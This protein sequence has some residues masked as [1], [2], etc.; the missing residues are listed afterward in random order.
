MPTFGY[1][2]RP[3]TMFTRLEAGTDPREETLPGNQRITEVRTPWVLRSKLLLS[4]TYPRSSAFPPR[5]ASLP[6]IDSIL[7]SEQPLNANLSQEEEALN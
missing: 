2:V 6:A 3:H 4:P 5:R 7:P 1:S